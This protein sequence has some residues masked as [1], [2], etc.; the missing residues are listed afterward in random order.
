MADYY[1]NATA[2]DL[3]KNH[4]RFAVFS[5]KGKWEGD[6]KAIRPGEGYLFRRMGH[7]TVTVSFY[8][9][10]AK[11]ESRKTVTPKADNGFSNQ[12]AATNMTMIATIVEPTVNGQ[13]LMAYIGDE[14]VGTAG[15][16]MVDDEPLYFL[17]IQCDNAG[18]LRFVTEEGIMLSIV[19]TSIVITFLTLTTAR[20]SYLCSCVRLRM[21]V[22]TK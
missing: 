13:R 8:D 2:G 6:L 1:Q 20:R 10:E 9:N 3:I 7:G 14:L 4:D 11:T 15:P 12:R 21:P 19:N 18:E 16:M 17:T 22:H 5:E